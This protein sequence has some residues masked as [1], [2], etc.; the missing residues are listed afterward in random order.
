MLS[1]LNLTEM[2]RRAAIERWSGLHSIEEG[3]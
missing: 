2:R 1:I 3:G